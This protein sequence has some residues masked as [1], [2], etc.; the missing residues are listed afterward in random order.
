MRSELDWRRLVRFGVLAFVAVAGSLVYGAAV[1]AELPRARVVPLAILLTVSTGFSWLVLGALLIAFTRKPVLDLAET[2][3][4]TMA[5]GEG[6]LVPAAVLNWA[7]APNLYPFNT[8][9]LVLS[10][11]LMAIVFAVR[12]GKLG[13]NVRLSICLWVLGL[14]GTWLIF[15]ALFGRAIM[16]VKL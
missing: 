8:A 1:G 12:L 7:F 3:L 5:I 16:G 14:N 9:V 6:V 15:L 2:C 4:V 13:V 11:V 10:N